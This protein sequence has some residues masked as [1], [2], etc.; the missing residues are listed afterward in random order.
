M[1]QPLIAHRS[2]HPRGTVGTMQF[3][4]VSGLWQRIVASDFSGISTLLKVQLSPPRDLGTGSC[5]AGSVHSWLQTRTM[6]TSGCLFLYPCIQRHCAVSPWTR[7]VGRSVQRWQS[8]LHSQD[9]CTPEC[10]ALFP[11]G[12]P[13]HL[14]CWD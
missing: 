1:V 9:V 2:L 8:V 7:D 12:L 4:L 11:T 6:G 10:S 3:P 14:K 13:L 5:L